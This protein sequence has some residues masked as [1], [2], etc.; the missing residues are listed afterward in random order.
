MEAGS[1][2][3]WLRFRAKFQ[4]DLS[5]WGHFNDVNTINYRV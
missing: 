3:T 5:I 4:P 1:Y 2:E